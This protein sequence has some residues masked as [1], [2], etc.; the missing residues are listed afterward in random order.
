MYFL[1]STLINLISIFQCI[2]LFFAF[3]F[4]S[5]F[6]R[7]K[8]GCVI[9]VTEIAG[10]LYKYSKIIPSSFSVCL[11]PHSFYGYK[12][13]LHLNNYG[14]I[15]NSLIK[16]FIGPI[17]LG[18]LA[19]RFRT[20]IYLWSS[21][22]LINRAYEF[23]F[24]KANNKKIVCIF[25]GDEIRSPMEFTKL[26]DSYNINGSSIASN[27]FY[28]F[29]SSFDSNYESKRKTT[30]LVSDR[31]SDVCLNYRFDQAS[32]LKSEQFTPPYV[33]LDNE[34]HNIK[35]KFFNLEEIKILHAASSKS[36]GNVFKGTKYV[37]SAIQ[38]LKK[39][40]YKFEYVELFNERHSLVIEELEKTHIVLNQFNALAPG[41]FGIEAMAK[42][43]AVLMSANPAIESGLPC[44]PRDA[45]VI[46]RYFEIYENLKMLLDN[47]QLIEYYAQNG[48]E[49]V[50]N[51]YSE[52][53]ASKSLHEI[54]LQNGVDI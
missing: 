5:I 13:D 21:G 49:Y 46:T 50:K 53:A 51:N 29:Y 30:A 38:R 19:S 42:K 17:I 27:E 7:L 34:F 4:C 15:L 6:F 8:K 12:Y 36:H 28:D 16:I 25:L 52:E 33:V 23:Y 40:G 39:E 48:Y 41:V 3:I 2:F 24:L 20:F 44:Q 35:E 11:D 54:L 22:F 18:Y 32:H 9:G 14:F 26:I 47:K 31:Y 1:K 45:W 37:N 10:V 43:C